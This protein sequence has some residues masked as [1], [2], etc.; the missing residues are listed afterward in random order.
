V[1]DLPGLLDELVAEVRALPGISDAAAVVR[2][3]WGAAPG[4]AIRRRPEPPGTDGPLELALVHGGPVVPVRPEQRT[5]Q[6][7]LRLAAVEAAHKGTRYLRPDG[8]EDFQS[9]GELL[10]DA[11]RLLG[12]LRRA[13]L[14][15][16]DAALFQFADNRAHVTAFWACV[17]GGFLPTPVG[18]ATTYEHHNTATRKLHNTWRL[19]D[20]PVILTDRTTL[21]AVR[22]VSA[23][24][25][26]KSVQTLAVEDLSNGPEDTDWFPAGPDDPVLHLLTSGST[27]IP[28]CVRHTHGSVA[29]R[30]HSVVRARG[31]TADD[32]T[33]NWM[34]LDHVAIVMYNVRDV[35]LGCDHVNATV[36]MFLADPPAWLRWMDRYGATNT[37]AP[38]FAYALVLDHAEEI[39]AANWDLSSMRHMTNAAEPI[40]ARTARRFLELLAPHGLPA[41]A[42]KPCWGMSETCSGVT[43]TTLSRDQP[44]SAVVVVHRDHLDGPVTRVPADDPHALELTLLGPP[45]P[46]LDLRIVDADGRTVPRDTIGSLEVR[47]EVMLREYYGN[48]GAQAE[49]WTA[50]GWFRTGDLGFVHDGQL[51][52]CGRS[53]DQIVVNGVNHVAHE[54]EAVAAQT[55]GVLTG[56][57]AAGAV[58]RT[59]GEKL[60]LFFVPENNDPVEVTRTVGA[61]RERLVSEIG[62]TPEFVVAVDPGEFPKTGSGKIQR[63]Q[64]VADFHAGL[65]AGRDHALSTTDFD[66]PSWFFTRHWT[67]ESSV[68]DSPESVARTGPWL[69]LADA[70][71]RL[72]AALPPAPGVVVVLVTGPDFAEL[73]D[74]TF[75]VVPTDSDHLRSALELTCARFGTP[76]TVFDGRALNTH[77]REVAE[78]LNGVLALIRSLLHACPD[79]EVQVLTAQG[80]RVLPGDRPNPAMT[81]LTGL[82]RTAAAEETPA[83]IRLVDLPAASG[84]WP[85]ALDLEL[86][87]PGRQAVSAHREGTRWSPGLRPVPVQ[88]GTLRPGLR[89]LVTGGLGG[90]GHTITE[91]LVA[92]YGAKVLLIGRTSAADL[93]NSS[94]GHRLAGLSAL[95]DVQYAE[96][97]V[98]DAAAVRDALV[99]AEQRWGAPVD[100]VLHLAGADLGTHWTHPQD[101]LVANES[102][103]VVTALCRPKVAGTRALAEVLNDRPSTELILFSSVNAE[104]GGVSFGAYSAANSFLSGFA[105]AAGPQVRSLAWTTWEGLGMSEGRSDPENGQGFLKLDAE[106]GLDLFVTALGSDTTNMIIGL[107]PASPAVLAE[108]PPE[109]TRVAEVIVAYSRT[110]PAPGGS[111]ADPAALRAVLAR[112][113]GSVG[114]RMTARPVRTVPRQTSGEPDERRLLAI[115]SRVAPPALRHTA[116]KTDLE[117]RIAAVWQDTLQQPRVGRDD[118]FFDLGGSSLHATRL[119]RLISDAAGQEVSLQQFYQHP[120]VARLASMLTER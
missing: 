31:Y 21:P 91:H 63:G 89:Y 79:A 62:I 113:T 35:F 109:H 49:S 50:D 29:A 7:A 98:A 97:D 47:G 96:A 94:K 53:K 54:I 16:G 42:M 43:Y 110:D 37:L 82:V 106:Q 24:W 46:G 90:V 9:Y 68:D 48:P 116:P 33:I 41:D 26:E 86:R 32:V 18:V 74:T 72:P 84:H 81:A 19:L 28:K 13:G 105:D 100:A 39:A 99:T 58:A 52:L 87:R 34:P 6:D 85:A 1:T 78:L 12:G 114:V 104:F 92:A 8:T 60:A 101:H 38:N 17:L 10:R 76:T 67:P 66:Q 93:H 118:S 71:G 59:D 88:E 73:D 25:Q 111:E 103:A 80:Q 4:P 3:A 22:G 117:R 45:V 83:R 30:T 120:T 69:V 40:I 11:Q 70:D 15:P 23:L 115:L 119:V 2:R 61:L 51:V 27:G 56:S 44:G 65:F 57:V 77:D 36:G 20:E 112:F 107:D 64:L 95:G 5:L 102:D 108:L 14:R 55:E 75:Q